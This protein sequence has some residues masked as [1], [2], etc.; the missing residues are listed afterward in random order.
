[1]LRVYMDEQRGS[2]GREP[3]QPAS[4]SKVPKPW[5]RD[6]GERAREGD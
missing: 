4:Q 3:K 1:M 6:E 5:H 2:F